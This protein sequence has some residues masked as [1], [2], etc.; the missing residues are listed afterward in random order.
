M[1][2]KSGAIRLQS[3]RAVVRT[4]D[5]W[6]EYRFVTQTVKKSPTELLYTIVVIIVYSENCSEYFK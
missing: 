6:S 1:A 2:T 3:A 4:V 5:S